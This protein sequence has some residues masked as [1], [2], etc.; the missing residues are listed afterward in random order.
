[1]QL[2]PEKQESKKHSYEIKGMTFE[3]FKAAT[4]TKQCLGLAYTPLKVHPIP[5]LSTPSSSSARVISASPSYLIIIISFKN[6][7]LD[8]P[9]L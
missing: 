7:F 5:F 1:M 8:V 3:I 4:R 6:L 9:D 2:M